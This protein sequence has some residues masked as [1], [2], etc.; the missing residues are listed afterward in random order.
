MT[1]LDY[2]VLIA[3]VLLLASMV[4]STVAAVRR[5]GLLRGLG[6]LALMIGL[7]IAPIVIIHTLR[8][9]P[10]CTWTERCLPSVEFYGG[11]MLV[12]SP[13]QRDAQ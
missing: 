8:S 4:Q 11:G 1:V 5:G 12:S 2:L 3:L 10:V 6:E 7:L 13:E 9:E